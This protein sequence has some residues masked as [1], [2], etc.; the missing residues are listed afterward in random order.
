M[1][2]N[3]LITNDDG[4]HSLGL[5]ALESALKSIGRVTVVAPDREMSATSHS[6]TLNQPLRYHQVSPNR[7][8]V[9]GTP[10][11]CV[12]LASLRILEEK[13]ALVVSG[14]NRGSNVGDDI[15][16]SGTVA[17]ASEA[18]LQG[19]PGIA[20]STYAGAEIDF[21]SVASVATILA[22]RVLE[23]G[24]PP[25]VILN[26]NFPEN[27][28]GEVR[29]TCQGRRAGKTVLV[30]NLDPR[31]REYFWLHEEL[32]SQS[33]EQPVED[34]LTDFAAIAAGFVSVTPLRLDRTAHPY[35]SRFAQWVEGLQFSV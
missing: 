25:D 7:F 24:L 31:G 1:N 6:I 2:P 18:A 5:T 3:I 21:D 32:H 15:N 33:K 27:W 19:I 30:E 11:D 26:V 10:A 13:P 35:L 4:I 28:N 20:V 8:A 29:W 12:I 16:Y 22:E 17:A 34:P 14:V 9:Q 23:Y